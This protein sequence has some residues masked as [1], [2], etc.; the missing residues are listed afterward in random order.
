LLNSTW[1]HA[2]GPFWTTPPTNANRAPP[3]SRSIS[4]RATLISSSSRPGSDGARSTPSRTA[5]SH[6]HAPSRPRVR[7]RRAPTG[8]L[9]RPPVDASVRPRPALAGDEARWSLLRVHAKREDAIVSRDLD[10]SGASTQNSISR[11]D[12]ETR[13][14]FAELD[15]RFGRLCLDGFVIKHFTRGWGFFWGYFSFSQFYCACRRNGTGGEGVRGRG[16]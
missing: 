12:Q 14:C 10:A 16:H 6:T 5:W 13:C 1:R 4:S 3:H 11:D 8:H 9:P 7:G 2:I 15:N